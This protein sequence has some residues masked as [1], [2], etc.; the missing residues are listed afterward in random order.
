[1]PPLFDCLGLRRGE[2]LA[3]KVSFTPPHGEVFKPNSIFLKA[4]E[5]YSPLHSY[6]GPSSAFRHPFLRQGRG[7]RGACSYPADL[8]LAY[9]YR[10][11]APTRP[12][13]LSLL[14]RSDLAS[15]CNAV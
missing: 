12:S 3:T 10:I 1:M 7:D 8:G 2:I 9:A 14:Q 11:K 4:Q 15:S 5:M 13:S 6:G